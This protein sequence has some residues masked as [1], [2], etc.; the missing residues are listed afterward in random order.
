[1]DLVRHRTAAFDLD[2]LCAAA[3]GLIASSPADGRANAVPDARTVRYY[4]SSGLVDRP[5]RY[6]GRTAVYGYRH[7]LQVLAVKGLQ[8]SGHSLAQIQRALAG[9]TTEQ[10]EVAVLGEVSQAS[11]QPAAPVARPWIAAEI[12]PGVMVA[13][14]PARVSDPDAV[15]ALLTRA[16]RPHG[17]SS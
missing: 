10:L 3:A 5:L 2:G 4:Q 11:P 7:L 16:L 13:I 14:D 17:V 15:T 1:M 12:A 9:T 8:A 6:D